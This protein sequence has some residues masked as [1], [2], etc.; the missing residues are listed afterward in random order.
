MARRPIP[1]RGDVWL[2]SLDPAV[3][4]EIRKTRPA[5]IV[6]NDDYNRYNWVVLVVPLTSH[7]EAEYDQVLIQPPEGGLSSPSVTLPDQLRAIDR[8]RLIKRMGQLYP[9]T[10][11][12]LS[13]TLRIVLDL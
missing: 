6:T 12:E 9:D 10:V 5:V 13:A 7:D 4:H 1:H 8:S 2:V 3:G 11:S